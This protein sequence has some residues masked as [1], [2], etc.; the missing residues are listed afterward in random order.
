[1]VARDQEPT[2]ETLQ[3]R[4]ERELGRYLFGPLILDS[5]AICGPF[6]GLVG[7]SANRWFVAYI[8]T[9]RYS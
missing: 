7:V 6:H 1:M 5:G 8:L 2:P 3:D 4:D 9:L